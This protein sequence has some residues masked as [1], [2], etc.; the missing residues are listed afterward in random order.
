MNKHDRLDCVIGQY[1]WFI[2]VQ[3]ESTDDIKYIISIFLKSCDVAVIRWYL[4]LCFIPYTQ[5]LKLLLK[6][7]SMPVI[8]DAEL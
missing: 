6:Y 1:S 2:M 4:N 5:S 8:R 3:I 7:S